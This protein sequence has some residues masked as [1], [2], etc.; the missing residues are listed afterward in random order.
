MLA[1]IMA[2]HNSAAAAAPPP[3]PYVITGRKRPPKPVITALKTYLET[4]I[5][6]P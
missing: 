2:L 4:K 1:A 6:N 5:K 3:E